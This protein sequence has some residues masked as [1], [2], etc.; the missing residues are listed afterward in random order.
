MTLTLAPNLTQSR[1]FLTFCL[2]W[3]WCACTH[4]C[5]TR[6]CFLS[7]LTA[8]P[9]CF[10]EFSALFFLDRVHTN[11][12]D[13]LQACVSGSSTP[14]YSFCLIT[15]LAAADMAKHVLP[16]LVHVKYHMRTYAHPVVLFSFVC[17]LLAWCLAGC[18]DDLSSGFSLTPPVL[19]SMIWFSKHY[20][21]STNTTPRC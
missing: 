19:E 20:R 15:S 5:R 12:L 1:S 17:F 8:G 3:P 16:C 10:E 9:L 18:T 13:L 14:V 6:Y 21:S 2:G 4:C 7:L 11:E